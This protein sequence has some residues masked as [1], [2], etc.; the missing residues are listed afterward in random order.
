MPQLVKGG[1]FV[2]GWTKVGNNGNIA[3]PPDAFSE[4]GFINGENL[5]LIAGSKTSGGFGLTK[6]ETLKESRLFALLIGCPELTDFHIPAG[7]AIKYQNRTYSWV[8]MKENY[9]T[10]PPDTLALFGIKSGNRLLVVRG[11]GLALGFIVRGPIVEE[12]LKH[13]AVAEYGP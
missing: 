2:F 13:P 1:K 8:L 12:A 4:Y 7:T 10:L 3:I 6:R 11:S 9:F 5:I